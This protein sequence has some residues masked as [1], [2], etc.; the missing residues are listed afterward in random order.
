MEK[1]FVGHVQVQQTSWREV[2]RRAKRGLK[3]KVTPCL[4][5]WEWSEMY[6]VSM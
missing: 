6:A 3:L 1:R 4:A 2:K 5:Y